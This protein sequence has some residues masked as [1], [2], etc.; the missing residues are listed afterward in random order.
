MLQQKFLTVLHEGQPVQLAVSIEKHSQIMRAVDQKF[1]LDY[2]HRAQL[3]VV[4][5]Y[6]RSMFECA[7]KLMSL[8]KNR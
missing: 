1:A 5:T 2:S 6:R 4:G 7:V 8:E 3:D